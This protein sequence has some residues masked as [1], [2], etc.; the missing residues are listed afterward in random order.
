MIKT[1]LQR[2]S[3]L[4]GRSGTSNEQAEGKSWTSLWNLTVPSKVKVFMW[5][6]ARH[7]LPTTDVLRRNM[8]VQDACPLCGCE[9]S[10][11]HA[12]LSCTMPRCIW[13]L[14]DDQLVAQMTSNEETNAKHWMFEMHATQSHDLF[15][16]MVVTLWSVWYVRRKAI[17]EA[18][19]QSPVQTIA[20]VD[21]CLHELQHL[22]RPNVRS[23]GVG[24]SP[25]P[26]EERWLAPPQV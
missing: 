16:R 19:F 3:W 10:W 6:L 12:L 26:T 20:F 14:S 25:R 23:S 4:E 24:R 18:I 11:R 13:A 1:K 2:E 7:S 21:S 15:T 5:R 8:A 9:D 22:Q 17:H